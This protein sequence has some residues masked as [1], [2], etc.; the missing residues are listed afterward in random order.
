[1]K[2]ERTG[3]NRSREVRRRNQFISRGRP[4]K[5]VCIDPPVLSPKPKDHLKEIIQEAVRKESSRLTL[6]KKVLNDFEDFI[7]E[8]M[9]FLC[10]HIHQFF[11][12]DTAKIIDIFFRHFEFILHIQKEEKL[13]GVGNVI[14]NYEVDYKDFRKNERKDYFNLRECVMKKEGYFIDGDPSSILTCFCG[15][16]YKVFYDFMNENHVEVE[17]DLM[18]VWADGLKIL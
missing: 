2:V 17:E 13:I 15:F 10:S 1:M 6:I 8:D 16:V 14:F 9:K 18:I 12:S 3:K 11:Q 5:S 4:K 7:L